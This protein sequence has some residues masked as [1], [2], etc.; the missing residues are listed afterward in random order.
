MS[1]AFDTLD[2]EILLQKLSF[3]G[4]QNT[5]LNLF[6]SYLSERS[7]FVS[8]GGTSSPLRTINTGVPQGSILGPLL[9]IIY[10]NDLHMASDKFNYILYA[11]DTTLI[12]NISNFKSSNMQSSITDNINIELDK[13]C[14]WLAVNKLSLNASKSNYMIFHHRQKKLK[15][16]S[17]P[18]LEMNH[19]T[20]QTSKRV[21]LFRSYSKQSYGLELAHHQHIKQN[22]KNYG[23]HEQNKE[24]NPTTNS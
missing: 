4:V 8:I 3:Y 13:I 24:I 10:I 6:K 18:I 7:Q 16:T 11:D 15:S 14:D 9:F 12:G 21:Q 23:H 20:D 5:S 2:H 1:K 17:I 22:N 19:I